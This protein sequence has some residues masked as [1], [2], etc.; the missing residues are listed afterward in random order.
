[1]SVLAGSKLTKEMQRLKETGKIDGLVGADNVG[2]IIDHWNQGVE[3]Q[4]EKRFNKEVTARNRYYWK[5]FKKAA[6]EVRSGR[7]V[8]KKISLKKIFY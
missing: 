1:M 8:A 7:R 2:R 5:L 4:K 6:D 3:K